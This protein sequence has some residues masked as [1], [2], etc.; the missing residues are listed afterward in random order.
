LTAL[1]ELVDFEH[2]DPESSAF[3]VLPVIL[4]CLCLA[5][6]QLPPELLSHC[7]A[8]YAQFP[9]LCQRGTLDDRL[10]MAMMFWFLQENQGIP[11]YSELAEAVVAM[12]MRLV[13][14][15][16]PLGLTGELAEAELVAH[17]EIGRLC[18]H[19][20]RQ[21]LMGGYHEFFG[22]LL[23]IPVPDDVMV[24]ISQL[25]GEEVPA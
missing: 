13:M 2:P 25:I 11:H 6:I 22:N 12:L 9:R 16:I 23:S 7:I 21:W 14:Y 17:G 3:R 5:E 24:S 10:V 15:Q 20:G 19:C 8:F 1:V 18:N 4:G